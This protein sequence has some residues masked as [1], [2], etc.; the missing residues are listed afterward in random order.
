M[1]DLVQYKSRGSPQ[2]DD[3]TM[4]V[5]QEIRQRTFIGF[6]EDLA[7]SGMHTAKYRLGG[8]TKSEECCSYDR[9]IS[10]LSSEE[11]TI[12][13]SLERTRT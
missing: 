7:C 12:K 9:C 10:N 1:A 13:V 6:S 3:Q 8:V 11:S 2:E 5:V 4:K